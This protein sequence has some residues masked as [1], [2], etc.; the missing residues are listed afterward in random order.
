ML[1]IANLCITFRVV[2][3]EISKNLFQSF[4]KFPKIFHRHVEQESSLEVYDYRVTG[5]SNFL[6][7]SLVE[8]IHI[9]IHIK[10]KTRVKKVKVNSE[11]HTQVY[12]MYRAV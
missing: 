1:V 6:N 7:G 12:G 5:M 11:K 9:H 2:S 3:W 4:R 8:L 10:F